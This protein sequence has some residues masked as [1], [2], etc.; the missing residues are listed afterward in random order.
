MYFISSLIQF[1]SIMSLGLIVAVYLIG[2]ILE[3]VLFT[4]VFVGDKI[5]MHPVL[6]IFAI[7][8]GGQLAGFMGVLLALPVSAVLMVLIRHL[9][10]SYRSSYLFE[11]DGASHD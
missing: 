1:D 4:P 3:S 2:Q 9:L 7:M 8:A 11:G 6:V 10:Q 5:G